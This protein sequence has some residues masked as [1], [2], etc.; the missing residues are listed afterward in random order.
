MIL[1]E[2]CSLIDSESLY[3]FKNK[4]INEA[5]MTQVLSFVQKKYSKL[6]VSLI[7]T[8]TSMSESDRPLPS[9]VYDTFR[10]YEK[11]ILNLKPFKFTLDQQKPPKRSCPTADFT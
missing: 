10:P 3:D 11:N 5:M 9:Q 1:L 2:V 7:K 8:A 6:L 4:T